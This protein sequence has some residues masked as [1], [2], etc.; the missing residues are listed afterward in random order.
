V[1]GPPPAADAGRD[2]LLRLLLQSTGEAIYGVDLQGRC[3]F[4]NRA[5]LEMLGYDSEDEVLGRNIHQ[6]IHHTHPDGTHYPKEACQAR[7]AT[8]AHRSGHSDQEVHWRKDGTPIPVEWWSHPIYQDGVLIGA[9]L[10][11][12][13]ITERR[14]S[15]RELERLNAYN[16]LL[17]ESAGE[18]IFGVDRELRCTFAN[19]AAAAMLGY[20]REE[21]L[22]RDI[23]ALM[24]H[25]RE[26]AT[27][28]VRED[29]PIHRAIHRQEGFVAHEE[30]LW[31]K[32]GTAIPVQYTVNPVREAGRVSG[33]VVV[34][35][36]IAEARA[37]ARKMD[38]L[39]THDTLTGLVNRREFEQ[40]L[41]RAVAAAEEAAAEHVLCYL[42]LDQFKVVNDSCGHAAGDELL[43]QLTALLQGRV[44]K[45]DTLARLG[46]DEFGVLL[47]HCRLA[48]ALPLAEALRTTVEAFRFV[49]D[50]RAFCVGT[51]IGVVAIDHA[52]TSAAA[53]LSAADTACYAA[54]DGGRN[55]VHV[56]EAHDE[57]TIRRRGEMQ[58]VS[59]IREAIENGHFS[60]GF[61]PI[62][63]LDAGEAG[64]RH[65][66][67]L[68][69]MVEADGGE[70][71]PGAFIPAAERFCLMPG[72]DRWVIRA[73]F[74]WLRRNEAHGRGLETCFINIS[75][76]S[77]GQA[78]FLGYIREQLAAS[79]V[80]P[81]MICFEITETAAVAN[82]AQAVHFM[83]AL[84]AQGCRFALDD[85]GSGMSS[86]G[87]LK[88]L[89]VDFLKIDG[90]FI[91][92][93]VDDPVDRTMVQAINQ[94]GQAMGI[95]TIAEFVESEAI[96][97]QVRGIG[98]DFAQGHAL[99]R[100][101]PLDRL[102]L[103]GRRPSARPIP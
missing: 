26:D 90:T 29:C 49:W 5:F 79:G 99:A 60:L 8:F 92:G 97:E 83:R 101:A 18:G 64:C 66:E 39:A 50:G 30:V 100:P 28:G 86:F 82:L 78:A 52:A 72:I 22:G 98:I 16:R 13:D 54:K 80:P 67:L 3:T 57:E 42:D 85:F 17:L 56:Y 55:R 27:P 11:F 45:G 34:F 73:A 32:D 68:L 47:E 10:N 31:R 71:L 41:E 44:R 65:I 4:V 102:T 38:Y 63:A 7:L 69:R 12:V 9:V 6:L 19:A 21:L 33:A 87:Y 35:R 43:R 91:R 89:P 53:V 62:H 93:M 58:W 95:R 23:F 37:L 84:K 46:G 59:R 36:N 94:V 88:N 74:D 24:H 14:Q 81:E 1:P 48:D 40:R 70:T 2:E 51:S 76:Q 96:L 75:G 15:E 25:S 103:P 20:G 77:L 61:Q